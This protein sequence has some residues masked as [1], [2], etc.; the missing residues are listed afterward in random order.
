L[1]EKPF[2][3]TTQNKTENSN[4]KHPIFF[5]KTALIKSTL[6]WNIRAIIDEEITDRKL[7]P[8]KLISV[9]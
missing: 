6:F 2:F 1:K 9:V 8:N 7:A 4:L 5:S 3:I